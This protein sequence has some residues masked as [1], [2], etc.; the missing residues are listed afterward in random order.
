VGPAPGWV[1]APAPGPV[2]GGEVRLAP[3][4]RGGI[5]GGDVDGRWSILF[6]K[7]PLAVWM[8]TESDAMGQGQR[9]W[10]V[11][12]PPKMPHGRGERAGRDAIGALTSSLARI[13]SKS[14]IFSGGFPQF[15]FVPG[16]PPPAQPPPPDLPVTTRNH[17]P[18]N[19]PT[20]RPT[21]NL[22][23]AIRSI[24][25]RLST[26]FR[27]GEG[28]TTSLPVP[29]VV[30]EGSRSTPSSTPTLF[31]GGGGGGGGDGGR[32]R[33]R[34]DGARR[35]TSMTS[36]ENGIAEVHMEPEDG[37][38]VRGDQKEEESGSATDTM[39]EV[40]VTRL[41]FR[42]VPLHAEGCQVVYAAI[43]SQLSKTWKYESDGLPVLEPIP[44]TRDRLIILGKGID[45]ETMTGGFQF[46]TVR[47]PRGTVRCLLVSWTDV[48]A[49]STAATGEKRGTRISCL[50]IGD[51]V[52]RMDD[53]SLEMTAGWFDGFSMLDCF[54]DPTSGCVLVH[55]VLMRGGR[56]VRRRFGYG[57]RYTLLKHSPLSPCPPPT[58]KLSSTPRP[59]QSIA[60][61]YS[62]DPRYA[63]L[64]SSSSSLP[65][66]SSSSSS[67]SSSWGA[68][69]ASPRLAPFH[70]HFSSASSVF[71]V[72]PIPSSASTAPT[73]AP[74]SFAHPPPASIG[75][76]DH[77]HRPEKARIKLKI[78]DIGIYP[79]F[80]RSSMGMGKA[81]A[82][83]D[84]TYWIRPHS[85]YSTS[86]VL[87]GMSSPSFFFCVHGI[88][89]ATPEERD[90]VCLEMR[91]SKRGR[92]GEFE[93]FCRRFPVGVPSEELL[94]TDEALDLLEAGVGSASGDVVSPERIA[95]QLR[96]D[97]LHVGSVY[98]TAE[99]RKKG[100]FAFG[101]ATDVV[102]VH[103]A[104]LPDKKGFRVIR[105]CDRGE[106]H[107]MDGSVVE[108][109]QKAARDNLSRVDLDELLAKLRVIGRQL[110]RAGRD[111]D[112][113]SDR[114]LED[115]LRICPELDDPEFT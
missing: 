86:G 59:G 17:R 58:E 19:P 103:C 48:S 10:R 94:L 100:G 85:D 70:P 42:C 102:R 8:T 31:V 56:H 46:Y 51:R 3:G 113:I 108:H 43:A 104:C 71:Y 76:D 109:M 37:S 18:T 110:E 67:S 35:R 74:F 99:T 4:K 88:P 6:C 65:V 13:R 9:R 40:D 91:P 114:D 11:G 27:S 5:K 41:P 32:G 73:S 83:D 34:R 47:Q 96:D 80:P 98:L 53:D 95:R 44:L 106:A 39:Q 93:L 63:P 36:D 54:L 72:P 90:H 20:H 45:R 107:L 97:R 1:G 87:W 50:M 23:H 2:P 25:H 112:A 16:C 7:P 12:P 15:S 22:R 75:G 29:S 82:R 79:E 81:D 92:D 24:M 52:W 26:S 64:R 60:V 62:Y 68:T 61:S 66:S 84:A 69:P 30:A 57:D 111:E 21:T 89:A 14:H 105:A 101:S 38:S 33:D 49:A 78:A 77:A 28:P 115:V 55:D